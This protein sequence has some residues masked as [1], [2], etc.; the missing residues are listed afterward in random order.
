MSTV[1]GNRSP[2]KPSAST[3]NKITRGHSCLSCQQRKVKCDGQ[4][5]CST[6]VKSRDECTP[7]KF[8]KA[9][10]RRAVRSAASSD[11]LLSR[12]KQCEELLQAHGINIEDERVVSDNH[13]A[14]DARAP[15]SNS[16]EGKM[17][18][19]QGRPRYVEKYCYPFPSVH[20]TELTG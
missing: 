5:P 8:S 9:F 11:L 6:C 14:Q 15:A 12:L 10:R 7:A 1:Y 20:N 17:I 4:R 16:D 2:S 13:G 18:F 19:D 3:A